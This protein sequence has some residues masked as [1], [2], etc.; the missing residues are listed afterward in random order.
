MLEKVRRIRVI[1]TLDGVFEKD[2]IYYEFLDYPEHFYR[3]EN[4]KDIINLDFICGFGTFDM[5]FEE[6]KP[7]KKENTPEYKLIITK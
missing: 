1:E 7:V 3:K 4:L 5:W 2:Q 6:M